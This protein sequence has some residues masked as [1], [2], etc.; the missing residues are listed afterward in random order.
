M[1]LFKKPTDRCQYLLPSSCHPSHVCQNIPKSLGLRLVRIV[2]NPDTLKERMKELA[3]LLI[4]RDYRK[5]V[6]YDNLNEVIKIPR[7][8]ALKRVIRDKPKRTIFCLTFDPRLPDISKILKKHFSV[9]IKDS[10][11]RGCFGVNPPMVAWR[12]CDSLKKLLVK[13]RV[14]APPPRRPPRDLPGMGRCLDTNCPVRPYVKVGREITCTNTGDKFTIQ[15]YCNCHTTGAVY[16]IT[17]LKCNEQ[18]IGQSGREMRQRWKEHLSYVRDNV[19]STGTHFNLPGH[20][21][22]HMSFSVLEIVRRDS[23]QY[24][25]TREELYI[26]KFETKYRGMNNQ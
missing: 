16:C 3:D 7:T 18:Y 11:M 1:D 15:S 26:D 24:R 5:K 23:R 25:E 17:C 8:E 21:I 6:V 2:T 10:F 12:K 19:R 4:S 22:S 9:L 14:P 13:S 20:D